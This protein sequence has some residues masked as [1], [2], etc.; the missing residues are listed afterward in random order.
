M[1][2]IR[3]KSSDFRWRDA[4][5]AGSVPAP[6]SADPADSRF[7]NSTLPRR[8]SLMQEPVLVLNA[9]YE[10]INVT[11]VRRAIVLLLKGVAQAGEMH[12]AEIHLAGPAHKVPPVVPLPA[13]P[14]NSDQSP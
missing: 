10:P 1:S 14:P 12:S 7:H 4:C 2:A 6:G 9:T 13:Y 3:P 5:E 11:A 8:A